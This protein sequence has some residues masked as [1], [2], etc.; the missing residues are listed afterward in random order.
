VAQQPREYASVTRRAVAALI[1]LVPT[2][3]IG[4]VIA[5]MAG[6]IDEYGFVL[7]GLPV[8]V[9]MLAVLC[10]HAVAEVGFH[11]TLGKWLL[12]I[13]VEMLD[14][15]EIGW[16]ASFVRNIVR[17]ADLFVFG[18]VGLIAIGTSEH[19]QRLGDRAAGTVVR[20]A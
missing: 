16:G 10:Y 6:Q 7:T 14:G 18:L 17:L 8:V 12:G 5:A 4:F 9:W 2:I 1:D 3:G 15:S 19:K 13:R 20:R 11:A